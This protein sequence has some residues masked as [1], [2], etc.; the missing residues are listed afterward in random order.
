VAILPFQNLS[1]DQEWGYFA[2]GLGDALLTELGRIHELKVI[3]RTSTLRYA[4]TTQPIPEIARQLGVDA[5]VEGS[6]LS[7]RERVR[8]T[9][10]LIDGR[11]DHHR[12]ANSYDRPVDDLIA[13]QHDL[14]NA[15]VREMGVVVTPD[16]ARRLA[17]R[18]QVSP[19][20]YQAYLRGRYFWQQRTKEGLEKAIP[21][22]EEAIRLS[23][24]YAAAYAGLSDVHGLLPR[25]GTLDPRTALAESKKHALT[26][27]ALDPGVAEAHTALAK[28]LYTLDWN[29][30]E[31]GEHFQRAIDLNP[32]YATAHHWHSLFLMIVG[33]MDEG[34]AA[35]LRAR[36]VDPVAPAVHA[37]AAW[38]RYLAGDAATAAQE[39]RLGIEMAPRHLG[40]HELLAWIARAEGRFD[41]SIA[42][43]RTAIEIAGD[44]A[45][46]HA[47]LATALAAA[48]RRDEAE[49]ILKQ[50]ETRNTREPVPTEVFVRIHTALGNLDD[51]FRWLER[52]AED[53]SISYYL[54]DLRYE[55]L[56]AP[57]RRDPRLARMF[58]SLG[59]DLNGGV[60]A[61][62]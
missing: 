30:A 17:A 29:W 47:A 3:S 7:T 28:A 25:Y 15:I 34:L 1:S 4:G 55:P 39:A 48:G 40:N 37:H 18:P 51:A 19:D 27:L 44:D 46:P 58:R 5:V 45:R 49:A 13:L 35:A 62:G 23:P 21:F 31:S 36:E 26:A 54:F 20:A 61:G 60:A 12:W 59:L 38:V 52:S 43:F 14:V 24:A 10:Q 33:R 56:Y 57:L 16:E 9:V 6:V 53:R 11:T 42:S 22:F 32:S 8:V 41:E 2:A 50:L